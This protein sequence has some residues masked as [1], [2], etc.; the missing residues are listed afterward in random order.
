MRSSRLRAQLAH[1]QWLHPT[2]STS[3]LPSKHMAHVRSNDEAEDGTPMLSAIV[4][5]MLTLR[6]CPPLPPPQRLVLL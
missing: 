2:I 3:A 6:T 1:T 5:A 4:L